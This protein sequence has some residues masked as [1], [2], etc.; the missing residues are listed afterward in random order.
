M[1]RY[2]IERERPLAATYIVKKDNATIL[3]G[4]GKP[5]VFHSLSNAETFVATA[6]R[7]DRRIEGRK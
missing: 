5:K 1:A 6:E 2:E 7:R 3:D 4:R